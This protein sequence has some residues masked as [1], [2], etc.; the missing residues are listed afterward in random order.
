MR[1]EERGGVKW[2][3]EITQQSDRYSIQLKKG[4]AKEAEGVETRKKMYR[5][6]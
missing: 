3:Q 1:Q 5:C 2:L 4:K 6:N